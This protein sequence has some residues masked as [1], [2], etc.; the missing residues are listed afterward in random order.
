MGFAPGLT[1]VLGCNG[2]GKTNL[3]EA[4]AFVSRG[5]S[6]RGA[7]QEALVQMGADAAFVRAELSVGQRSVL[8][9]AEV[10]RRGRP[11]MQLNRQRV[12]RRAD[13]LA[14]FQVTVFAPDDLEL[15][16]GGPA[17]RRDLMDELLVSLRPA[18]DA[19]RAELDKILRQRNSLLRQVGGRLPPEAATT[20][21]VW[22]DRLARA[23]DE[24]G[25]W[26]AELVEQLAPEVART[27]AEL[28][29]R[30]DPVEL[31]LES[32]WRAE[33][34]ASNLAAARDEDV[35]RG[36][37]TVGPHRDELEVRLAGM[38]A[39]THASQGEQ[40]TLALAVRLAGH[41]LSAAALGDPPA[42][43]LDDVF[44]ELDPLRSAALLEALPEGQA[45]LTSAAGLP[46][47]AVPGR[48]V[49]VDGEGVHGEGSPPSVGG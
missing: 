27:Y 41:R 45:I 1:A 22:D 3:L 20:L 34:L 5:Q 29:G 15:V 39:R 8:F 14:T 9:E 4:V 24:W 43:L 42:L 32:S 46:E 36:L 10:P 19:R 6:F 2:I 13:L 30:D 21:D 7:P 26:R 31:H 33:G 44:S 49:R 28:S 37:T 11:R 35:R 25:T 12:S 40:R 48:V 16:K 47:G 38:P 17:V 18:R 23:G